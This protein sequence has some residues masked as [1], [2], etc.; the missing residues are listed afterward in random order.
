MKPEQKEILY[1]TGE[2][3]KVIENSPHLESV[4]QKGYEVLYLS[5]PVDELIVQQSA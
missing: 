3:R 4:R 5:D 1:L 2:S